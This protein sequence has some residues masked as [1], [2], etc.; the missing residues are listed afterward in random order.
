MIKI[1]ELPYKSCG[2]VIKIRK[3]YQIQSTNGTNVYCKIDM[4]EY[5]ELCSFL[6][7]V[8]HIY[9]LLNSFRILGMKI[10]LSLST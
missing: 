1:D 6:K 5:F 9:I 8:P 3:M 10:L 2:S 4:I 7:T